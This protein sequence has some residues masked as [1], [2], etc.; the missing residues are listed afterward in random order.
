MTSKKGK[1][2]RGGL[3]AL[4]IGSRVRCTDDGVEGRIIWANSVALKVQ[5]DDGEHVTWRRDSL[6]GRPIEILQ[7]ADQDEHVVTNPETADAGQDDSVLVPCAEQCPIP[8]APEADTARPEQPAADTVALALTQATKEPVSPL[9]QQ[10]QEQPVLA[11]ADATAPTPVA[12]KRRPNTSAAPKEKKISALDAAARVLAETGQP[13]NCQEMIA[14]MAAKGYW[15]SPGG[16]TPQ[17]TLYSAI[18]REIA[19]KGANS[20]FQKADRGKFCRN[21]AV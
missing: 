21:D 19:V 15:S 5:W 9:P 20:R 4:K 16:K 8:H 11:S 7:P 2:E 14:E 12:A 18:I 10:A 3:S 13:M 17:A 6:A 1:K